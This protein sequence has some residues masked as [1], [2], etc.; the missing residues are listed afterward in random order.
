MADEEWIGDRDS[1]LF[2]LVM[3]ASSFPIA[4]LPH[5]AHN[6]FEPEGKVGGNRYK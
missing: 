3:H 2:I 6:A 1:V 5:P 4:A